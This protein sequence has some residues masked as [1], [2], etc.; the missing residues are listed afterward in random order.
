SSEWEERKFKAVLSYSQFLKTQK[1]E[2]EASS[3]L[4]TTWQ[5]YEQTSVATETSVSYISE[6]A[7]V[8]KTV[9][10]ASL[11]L[12][13]YKRVAQ[14]YESTSRTQTSTYKEIQQSIQTTSQEV[15]KVVSSSS[16][17]TSETT[18]EEIV[19]EASSSIT[20]VDQTSITAVSSLYEIYI[21]QHRWH[22]STR[23]I[24]RVLHGI[25]PN[26]FAPSL[27]DVTLPGKHVDH[28]IELAEKLSQC[29][30]ARRR[31]GKEED[32]RTRI[33]RAVRSDRQ[34]G[35]KLLDRVTT[36]LL[37]LFERTSQ[38]DKI[39]T[40]RQELLSD[41][42]GKYG[43]HHS[44]VITNLWALAELTRPRPIFVDYY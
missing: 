34:V 37:R 9:G 7:S 1:R 20:K 5:E 21:S 38:T 3:L 26:L 39:I 15:M 35:D 24:K 43:L 31:L 10:L 42:I 18:L 8:M 12:S 17:V 27:Q 30:H 2:Y 11:A 28:C 22:D 6:I 33:Y 29:Y 36:E 32:I 23:L 44:I 25:W 41:Y 13:V 19:Y 4:T 16:S 40:L 14:F